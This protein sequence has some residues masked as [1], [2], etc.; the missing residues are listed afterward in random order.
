M[1]KPIYTYEVQQYLLACPNPQCPALT[2]GEYGT[3]DELDDWLTMHGRSLFWIDTPA[4]TYS[5]VYDVFPRIAHGT[6]EYYNRDKICCSLCNSGATVTSDGSLTYTTTNPNNP[7]F[8][9]P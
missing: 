1:T 6:F 8:N 4:D 9:A 5:K 7:F 3:E 2:M